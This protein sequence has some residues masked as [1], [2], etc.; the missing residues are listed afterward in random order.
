MRGRYAR[1]GLAGF[2]PRRSLA[3]GADQDGQHRWPPAMV[4]G[5]EHSTDT[6]TRIWRKAAQGVGDEER[7]KASARV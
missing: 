2:W 1:P 3:P 4:P 7:A 5:R 6:Q